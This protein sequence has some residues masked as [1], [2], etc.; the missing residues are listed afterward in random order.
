MHQEADI[1]LSGE[2]ADDEIL[3]VF[4]E[5]VTKNQAQK[6]ARRQEAE[7]ITLLQENPETVTGIVHLSQGQTVSEAAAQFE[8]DPDIAYVQPNYR[9][10]LLAEEAQKDQSRAAAAAQLNDS[11]GGELW[12]LDKIRAK[13]AWDLLDQ[14]K[15]KKTRVAVLD[16]GVDKTHPDLKQNL[17][18]DL[19]A[20]TS[21]GK[22]EAMTQGDPDGHGTHAA[23]IIGA[24]SNNN[25]GVAGVAAG[26]SNNVAEIMAVDVFQGKDAYTS[27]ISTGIYYAVEKGAKVINMSLGY[28]QPGEMD[29]ADL[30]LKNAVDY[31]VSQGVTVVCAAGN[32]SNTVK[33]YPADFESAISVI[34]TNREDQKSD[35]SNYGKEKDIS[36]PGGQTKPE[37]K[38]LSTV[39]GGL[40][41]GKAGTSMASP[42]VAGT[43]AMLY[44]AAPDLTVAQVKKILYATARDTYEKGHDSSSG[45]GIV[46]AYKAVSAVKSGCIRQMNLNKR[47][48]T[49]KW[50]SVVKL[51]VSL[52]PSGADKAH[53]NWSSS[54]PSVASVDAQG[55]V[56][57]EKP[58]TATV[59]VKSTDLLET[60]AS[61]KVTVPYHITYH[62]NGGKNHRLNP[63][64]YYGKKIRLKNPERKGYV[65]D[66]WYTD[67]QRTKKIT[68]F[69]KGDQRLYAKWK[70]VAVGKST[71][72]SVKR[73]SRTKGKVAY[74]K[75][76]KAKGYQ[77]AYSTSKKF[78][79]KTTKYKITG[80]R[81]K[82]LTN[83]KKGKTYYVKVRAYKKDSAGNRVYGK[84]SRI[85]KM[86][87]K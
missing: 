83:L 14:M 28:E 18:T 35:F 61:C 58:G 37:Q 43:A 22:V 4:E 52:T 56:R 46:D 6:A 3:V 13:E 47:T 80:A 69:S 55:N 42:V 1:S 82:T 74:K 79:K 10:T 72:S 60:S 51:S 67:R 45:Y 77:I 85:R 11:Y 75:I 24:A 64:V 19:C 41:A 76:T 49:L 86:S 20:D 31:A 59:T 21:E 23:G 81:T 87:E 9:Y 26:N 71:I 36:A 27:G 39:P 33:N 73:L 7:E 62:L 84:Y 30:V 53:L 48:L 8:K 5:D 68:S 57:G 40:Y 17:R 44:A 25:Q 63:E 70:K 29:M 38:I 16:T 66:G 50:G 34:S 78:T 12:H 2:Y 54:A 15:I 65:F 32:D